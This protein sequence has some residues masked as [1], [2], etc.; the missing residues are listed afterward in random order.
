[1]IAD[2][3][4]MRLFKKPDTSF[5]DYG[6]GWTIRYITDLQDPVNYYLRGE[7]YSAQIDQFIHDIITGNMTDDFSFSSA[8][9]TDRVID[10]IARL[11]KE[12]S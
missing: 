5:E 7:E 6:P 1:V 4:E 3:Q 11:G 10:Q 8:A 2:R 9:L 12:Q